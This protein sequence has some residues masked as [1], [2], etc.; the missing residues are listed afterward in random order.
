MS[1]QGLGSEMCETDW[2]WPC[3]A[4]PMRQW[5]DWKGPGDFMGHTCR[6]HND[7]TDWLEWIGFGKI[8]YNT[9]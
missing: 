7:Q 8:Y 6:K 2:E 3:R 4:K 1:H 9:L 5:C